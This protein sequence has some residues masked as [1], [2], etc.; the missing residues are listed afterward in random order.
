M[1]NLRQIDQYHMPPM[2]REYQS[3]SN[4]KKQINEQLHEH[5]KQ[6]LSVSF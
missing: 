5:W 6:D 1:D 2:D 4:K 3:F